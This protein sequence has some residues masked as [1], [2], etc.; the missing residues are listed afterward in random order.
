MM[1][2]KVGFIPTRKLLVNKSRLEGRVVI[3]GAKNSALKLL[4]ASILTD[5][6]VSI[7]N[8]P[9][10]LADIQIHKGMLENLGKSCTY[11]GN[12]LHI[13]YR[14]ALKEELLWDGPSI[15]NTLLIFGALLAR[16]GVAKVPLPGGC[17]LG[18]RK[19]DLHQMVLEKL[20]AKVWTENNY[21][22]G[23]APNG[24]K[25]SEIILPMRSTGATEN[26]IIS[27]SL[28]KGTTI[29]WGPHIRPE[30]IDLINFLCSMGAKI[31]VYGQ[32]NIYVHGVDALHG[33]KHT[34]MPDNLEAI[35]YLIAS[36]VTGGDIEIKNF[37]YK[38]LE[39]PLIY[40][41]ESGTKFFRGDDTLIVRG[42]ACFPVDISTGPYPGINSDMQPLF[43]VF[44]LCARGESRITDLR[45]PK[46]FGYAEELKKLN[47]CFTVKDNLLII[48]G[49]KPL[50]GNA[51]T[52]LD[53]RCGAALV[54]AGLISTGTTTIMNAGQIERGY[55]NI[56]QKMMA[57][58][59]NIAFEDI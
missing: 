54:I 25:G 58:G 47:A 30:I 24:L 26:A 40:L 45:F 11:T 37:P 28:A 42:G 2:Q 22:C 51:V 16:N 35:T 23:E 39:I 56:D 59:G 5:E 34:V 19:Y 3:S 18:E 10:K 20:G 21:L 8:C 32:E 7:Y 50:I 46:R 13:S 49:G 4:T 1:D 15:R 52:A 9:S 38:D 6:D 29:I 44:G 33:T 31:E 14:D 17:S 41:R 12:N 53:L 43:A 48:T 57:L 36:V 27:A 55:E